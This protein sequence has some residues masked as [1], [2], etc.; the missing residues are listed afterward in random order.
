MRNSDGCRE[1]GRGSLEPGRTA[2]GTDGWCWTIDRDRRRG[3]ECNV[4]C[5]C[6]CC[7]CNSR[8]MA[9]G[10]GMILAAWPAKLV[11]R[12]APAASGCQ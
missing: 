3:R 4:C 12:C 11:M 9:Q 7:C 6:C 5:Y 8:K 2:G 1:R 10:M